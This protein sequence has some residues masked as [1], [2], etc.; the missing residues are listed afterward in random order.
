MEFLRGK[1]LCKTS[2]FRI[3][4]QIWQIPR[5]CLFSIADLLEKVGDGGHD[6]GSRGIADFIEKRQLGK[7]G[8]TSL[9]GPFSVFVGKIEGGIDGIGCGLIFHKMRNN[10]HAILADQGVDAGGQ[11]QQQHDHPAEGF[12]FP[13]PYHKTFFPVDL[14][15]TVID[16]ARHFPSRR[17]QKRE[18]PHHS[19]SR[20]IAGL[21]AARSSFSAFS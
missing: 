10:R 15:R 9:V 6:I 16:H 18:H 1:R 3:R 7:G 2:R 20:V 4:R 17:I 13:E 21:S 8:C 12:A 11:N 19:F 14:A 5:G